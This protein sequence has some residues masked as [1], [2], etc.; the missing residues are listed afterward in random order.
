[1]RKMTVSQARTNRV[2]VYASAVTILVQTLL[3]YLTN[4][5]PAE[6]L[7]TFGLALAMFS[8]PFVVY[9]SKPSSRAFKYV[10]TFFAVT[11]MFMVL[12]DQKGN[13][14]N[15][16][17]L[18]VI[19]SAASL[20]FDLKFTLYTTAVLCVEALLGLLFFRAE[21]YPLLA[22]AGVLSLVVNFLVI[23]ALLA[24]QG[25]WGKKMMSSYES[26]YDKSITD[27][28]TNTHNR[29][30]FDDYLDDTIT[31]YRKYGE[32]FCIAILDIDNFKSFNDTYGHPVGD[33]VLQKTCQAIQDAIRK[34]DVLSRFGG[35]EF[36][37]VLKSASI[38]E[39][40][41]V[42]EKVRR[43]VHDNAI[44]YDGEDLRISISIGVAECSA[45]D[46]SA[47]LVKRADNALLLAKQRGK[48]RVES[49]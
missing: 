13:I 44:A 7:R 11:Y 35:E 49:L 4:L 38:Q 34:T 16:F 3:V 43:R 8:P 23:G 17:L 29:A 46:D 2:L 1:M 25:E 18:F 14:D 26:V 9:F 15:L 27:A 48:N 32:S 22:P 45:T 5:S 20:Y 37:I 10:F 21:L 41:A 19:L 30:F 12:Y 24:F 36:T 42:A 33:L 31:Q 47:S 39:A 6:T 40:R 28:L